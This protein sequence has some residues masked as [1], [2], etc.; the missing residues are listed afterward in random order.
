MIWS[1]LQAI[2]DT[3]VPI[4]SE[5]EILEPALDDVEYFHVAPQVYQLLK[6]QERL[7]GLPAAYRDRLKLK[8][9][10][11]VR[12]NLYIHYENERILQAFEDSG[13]AVIPL[14]GV[15]FAM[16]YFGHIGARG[17][18]DIDLLLHESDMK[19]AEACIRQFGF[20]C[21]EKP[22]RAHFHRSFSKPLAGTNHSL[23]VE[24]HWGLLMEGTSSFSIAPFWREAEPLKPYKQVMELSE[25]HQF[26]MI[27]LHGWKHALDSPKYLIDIVQLLEVSG[28]RISFDRL[29]Q[30]AS[31]H[32][33]YKRIAS[34]LSVVYK[35]FPYLEARKPL[36][37]ANRRGNWW[38]YDAG[39]GKKKNALLR[40]A[41]FLQYQWL[42]FDS[43]IH[44]L[45]ASIHYMESLVLFRKGVRTN[46]QTE[47]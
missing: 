42:D 35:Q 17:T 30:D 22:I 47:V 36:K 23:T 7:G 46:D 44:S 43:P 33:T 32:R 28:D 18:S 4:P 26:Y 5:P 39:R 9:D 38:Y 21:E 3:S 27:C 6:Q 11:T 13:I 41:R 12:T 2:Y 24:L 34:T 16:K 25:Y 15:R 20:T 31:I 10:E 29:L 45:A 40:Y 1:L 8:Y 14:K 19:R 37:L